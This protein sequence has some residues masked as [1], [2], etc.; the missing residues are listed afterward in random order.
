[1]SPR[2]G[3]REKE[4]LRLGYVDRSLS[5]VVHQIKGVYFINT[6][7][8]VFDLLLSAGPQGFVQTPALVVNRIKA[9]KARE[10]PGSDPDGQRSVFGQI[11]SQLRGVR[12]E[13]LRCRKDMQVWNV[14]FVGEG[15]VDVG[16][17]YRESITHMCA[18]LMSDATPLFI[19]SPNGRND[20]GLNRE[21]FVVNPSST[22]SLHLAMF[23][24]VGALLG[25]SLRTKTP[26][27]LDLPSIFWKQLLD[28]P[29]DVGDL[30]AVDKLCVQ[31][32]N[33]MRALERAKFEGLVDERFATQLSDGSE[34]E[35]KAGGKNVPVTWE[36]RLEFV[37]LAVQARLRESE[38]QMRAIRKGLEQVVPLR[39]LS[40]FSW[41]DIEVMVCGNPYID[42]EE[43]R[44]H[45]AYNG[46][47]ASSPVV[48]H[49]FKALHSF[50]H[51][52]R[53]LFLRFVWGRNRLPASAS[54]WSSRFTINAMRGSDETLPVAHTCFF[55]IDLPNYSSYEV[56]RSKLLYAILNC[57][58]I[59]IDFNPNASSLNAWVDVD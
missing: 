53:Q 1:V 40:L 48:R 41:Y 23:E 50:S 26:L 37:E 58:A 6:K 55:S 31:A 17:P 30:E 15:S 25:I 47:Q 7:K 9:N 29:V 10:A 12:F 44:R 33:E 51:E 16:G 49:L 21:K 45:T 13:T 42:V 24:F 18:D 39:M 22:S 5:H 11:F 35:L 56:L 4:E 8:S 14:A 32:L 38:K 57:Q 19:R 46:V 34:L 54:D 2:P 20:V 28:E 43:L 36:T 3:D 59:D 52:E 27:S